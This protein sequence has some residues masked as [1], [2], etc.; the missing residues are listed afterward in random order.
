MND[1]SPDDTSPTH[2][3]SP[4]TLETQASNALSSSPDHPGAI[5]TT[6]GHYQ[7]E[8]VIGQGGMGAVYKAQ[9]SSPR[10]TVALKV[11]KAGLASRTLLLRFEIEA[12]ILGKLDHPGIATIYE[13]GTFDQGQG[14]QPYFAMEFVKGQEL[15]DYANAHNLGTRDRLTLLAKIAEAVQHAHQKGIIH[16]DLKPSNILVNT[17]GQIKVLDF[18]VARA[19]DA[20]IQTATMQTD[21]GQLIGTIPYM[22]PEQASG[23]PDEL[24]TRSDVYA[25]GVIAYELLTGQMPYD[26]K[27]KMIHEAVRVIREDEPKA[28]SAINKSF[29]G[30]VEIIV[31]KALIKEKDRRYQSASDLRSDIDRYLNNE[32]IEARPP[33]TWYQLSKFSK[34]NKALVAGILAVIVVSITG[35]LISLNFAKGEAQ[36]KQLALDAAE[37]ARIAKETAETAQAEEA[38]R[39]D[40]L[41]RVADFQ[42]SQLSS[43]NA[44]LMGSQLREIIIESSTDSSKAKLAD[45]LSKINFTNIGLG[46]MQ[47][48]VFEPAINAIETQFQD[49]P[50]VQ[51]QLLQSVSTT[52]TKI[53]LIDLAE[54]PQ[55]SALDIRREQLGNQHKETLKSVMQLGFLLTTQGKLDEAEALYQEALQTYRSIYGDENPDTLTGMA[56][57]G[58]LYYEQNKFDQ[59]E[60]LLVEALNAQRRILGDRH[61]LTINTISL[62]GLVHQSNGDLDQAELL[63]REAYETNLQD[64]GEDHRNTITA[65][66]NLG[67][68]LYLQGKLDEA[69]IYYRRALDGHRRVYGDLHPSTLQS[70]SNMGDVLYVQQNIAEAELFYQEAE[71]GR[72]RVLGVYHPDTLISILNMGV[73][74]Y[75]Q[76]KLDEAEPYY[77]EGLEIGR[78]IQGDDHPATLT[79]INNFAFLLEAQ[80][81]LVEAENYYREALERQ[82]RVLGERHPHTTESIENIAIILD[83]QGRW[84]D[85]EPFHLLAIENA[86]RLD[87]S[88]N[89]QLGSTYVRF[90]TNLIAQERY[91]EANQAILESLRI[92]KTILPENHWLI[93]N[94]QSLLGESLAKQS[95]FTQAEPLLVQAAQQIQP[96]QALTHRR[97]EAIQRVV[98]L[99]TNWHAAQPNNDY[100]LKAQDWQSKLAPTE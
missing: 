46:S 12:Q 28:L 89:M 65:I 59:A 29:R 90:G 45:T 76:G 32:P 4:N 57:M 51:A 9:Q 78:A 44:E 100:N 85:A 26:L 94:T 72:R 64:L 38:K 93:W 63:L 31:S 82:K 99:Y 48:H 54:M 18:G 62:L 52:L 60:E 84:E 55:R 24:D 61:E 80:G 30:D 17:Q 83:M 1:P 7:I 23:N 70:I 15:L 79:A 58:R 49:Q 92:R 71:L 50:L 53:G 56:S 16:R 11:I 35:A 97:D 69:N 88:E 67:L 3:S 87:P 68:V 27:Q 39:A 47:S 73:I 25:L 20:D 6:I 2:P 42:S 21:I 77:R 33:S 36:Q 22:S 96:P 40:E 41:Q 13:A 14:Q 34:R 8:S 37:Q 75:A 86:H 98:D 74:R 10:R 95:K 5:P 66:N 43:I 81:K 19:T 91:Q